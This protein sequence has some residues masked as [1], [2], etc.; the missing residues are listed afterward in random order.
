M[1]FIKIDDLFLTCLCQMAYGGFDC[2]T[3]LVKSPFYRFYVSYRCSTR[4]KD[5][6]YPIDYFPSSGQAIPFL[7]KS[8]VT[9]QDHAGEG[10]KNFLIPF[11]GVSHAVM[12]LHGRVLIVLAGI[13]EF[14]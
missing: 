10:L 4:I 14:G 2:W 7:S 3:L 12:K 6:I 5:H 8:T 13:A 11:V 1:F 9:D